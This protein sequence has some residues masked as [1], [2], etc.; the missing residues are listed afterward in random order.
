MNKTQNALLCSKASGLSHLLGFADT[1]FD[2]YKVDDE[3]GDDDVSG[4]KEDSK[5][6]RRRFVD[7]AFRGEFA[8]R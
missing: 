6:E 8:F 2:E 7:D 4:V 1:L 5:D 3:D